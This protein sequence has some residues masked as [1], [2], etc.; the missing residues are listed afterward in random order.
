MFMLVI[1]IKMQVIQSEF[2]FMILAE[3]EEHQ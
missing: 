1:Q 3:A 2:S